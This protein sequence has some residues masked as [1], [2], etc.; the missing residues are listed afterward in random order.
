MV[1][2]RLNSSAKKVRHFPAVFSSKKLLAFEAKT[3]KDDLGNN[4]WTGKGDNSC[5]TT[6]LQ[7]K[8][9]IHLIIQALSFYPFEFYD[10]FEQ[11]E[12]L[13]SKVR[14]VDC[15]QLAE[16]ARGHEP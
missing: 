1:F 15:A 8:A 5:E 11:C 12:I 14:S 10:F 13:T 4:C 7:F 3:P 2:F 16:G 9:C 6:L